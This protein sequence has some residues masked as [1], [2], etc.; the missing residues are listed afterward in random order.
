[1]PGFSSLLTTLHKYRWLLLAL[2][3]VVVLLTPVPVYSRAPVE[4][5]VRVEASSFAYQPAVVRVNPG[6]MVTIELVSTDVV[7]GI[8]IDSYG[9]QV[10]AD[11]GQ[12]Q[13]LTFVADK[14]GSFRMRCSVTCGNLHPFM[15]GKL[16]V[17]TNP[18]LWKAGGLTALAIL[19]V[20]FFPPIRPK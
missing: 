19:A 13:R 5:T 11:P 6:D 7:H 14:V 15:I 16:V 9:V 3:A 2:L 18:L 17:G 8:Y 12:P 1:M 4:R 20:L 10:Q